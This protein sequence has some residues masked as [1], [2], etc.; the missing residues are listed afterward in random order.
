MKLLTTIKKMT[1]NKE[2]GFLRELANEENK[3]NEKIIAGFCS[4]C[5][6]FIVIMIIA[7]I[8]AWTHKDVSALVKVVG[9]LLGFTVLALGIS[10]LQ[11]VTKFM[12]ETKNKIK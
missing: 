2:E 8:V 1:K 12:A 9:L 4:L 6:A 3:L 11:N 10:S 5:M 7:L